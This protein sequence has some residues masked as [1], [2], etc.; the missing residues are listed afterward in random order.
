MGIFGHHGT[1]GLWSRKIL[2]IVSFSVRNS[3][4]STMWTQK[5][6]FFSVAHPAEVVFMAEHFAE[7]MRLLGYRHYC[8]QGGDWGAVITSQLAAR[9]GGAD[10]NHLKSFE[11]IRGDVRHPESCVALHVR[12]C[13]NLWKAMPSGASK[14]P[15]MRES[16]HFTTASPRPTWCFHKPRKSCIADVTL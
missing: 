5:I 12:L 6:G 10:L 7:L 11:M 1:L 8:A 14:D 13:G 9:P 3:W 4:I 16:C 15:A 2:G